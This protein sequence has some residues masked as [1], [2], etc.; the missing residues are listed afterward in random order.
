MVAT[1][2][3]DAVG[4][5]EDGGFT[6]FVHHCHIDSHGELRQVQGPAPA[7]EPR[8]PDLNLA[9]PLVVAGLKRV[10]KC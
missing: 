7:E 8:Q 4:A 3:E 5:E 6:D 10:R 2:F 1:A 9:K